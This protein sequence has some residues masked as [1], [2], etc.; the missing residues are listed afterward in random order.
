MEN[1]LPSCLKPEEEE[2][3]LQESL[4]LAE[5]WQNRATSILTHEERAIQ[6][7]LMRLLNH[8]TDKAVLTRLIDQSFRSS[9]N[10]RVADQVCWLLKKFGIPAYFP[11]S[12]RLLARLFLVVGRFFPEWAVPRMIE[13]MRSDSSRTIIH[14]EPEPFRAHM[15]KRKS[16]G[17]RMNINHLG[18]ALL[19][20]EEALRRL[21]K[22][23][24]ALESDE[25]EYISVKIS[26]IYSQIS[27]IGMDR[28]VAILKERLSQLYRTARD[29]CFTRPDGS[30][31][32]KFVNLDMEE[33]RDLDITTA[34]FT[35]TLDM[36]EFKNHSAGI[37][38]QAYLPDSHAIQRELTAWAQRRLEAG[39]SPVKLRIVKG[40]NM[41]MEQVE[42]SIHNWPLA[43]YDNKRDVDANYKRMVEF[44]MRPENIRA[45]NLGIASHNLF[46]VA[47]AFLLAKHYGVTRHFIFE[48]LEGMADHVRR[49]VQET[50]G[51]VLLYAPV[52]AKEQFINAI[53]YLVRRLDENT[54]PENFL[55]YAP[56]LKTGTKEW[57]FLREQFIEAFRH[58]NKPQ[59]T[60]HR[61][62]NR[63][64]ETFPVEMGTFT[65][66]EFLNEPDTDWALAPNRKW[67]E[68]I[69]ARWK[70]SPGD[71]PMEIPLAIAGNEIYEGRELRD[72]FDPSQFH[73]RVR[74]ARYAVAN[75][76]DVELAAATAKADPDGW[77][78]LAPR[79]R[80]AVLSKVAG[81]LRKARGDLIGAAAADTGKIFT[82][83]DGEVSEAI[84]FAEFYPHS[85]KAFTELA[86]V[87]A[88]GKG[89]VLVISPWNFPVS[90]PCGGIAASLAA[91]NR[92]IFKPASDAV[93]TAWVL[94][95]CFWK[96]GVSKNTLQFVPCPGAGTG[97][98]LTAHPAVNAII[99]TGGTD[100]GLRILKQRPNI[101]LNAETGGKNA[102]IVTA[103]SDRDQAVKNVVYSAFGNCGQKCSATSLLILD[104]EVHEDPAFREQLVDASAS[105]GVGSA[106]DF[107]NRM[108]PMIRPPSGDLENALTR[109]EP[110]E[111]WALKP[112]NIGGN[113]HTWSPGIKWNVQPR[114]YT[115]S[116]EFFG[117]VLAVMC[118]DNLDRAIELANM[119]GY[120]LTSGLE[121]LDVR[122]QERWKE[123]V[124]AGNLYVNRGTTGA[125]VLRQPFGGM[126]KSVIGSGMK[127]G[128]PD[129]VSQ[130][131]NFEETDFPAAGPIEKDHALLRLA[132]EWDLKIRWGEYAS[133]KADLEKTI[134]AIKSY[135]Y[136]FERH[137]AEGRDYFH[138]RGQD[139]IFRYLPVGA[140][141]VRL[142]EEDSLFEVL[143]RI[144]AAKISGCELRVSV[145]PNLSGPVVEFLRGKEGKHILGDSPMMVQS[146]RE[147]IGSM[148]SIRRIRYAAPGRVPS[149]V[150]L[151]AA[152]TGFYI[153]RTPVL[154]EG[155]IELLQY[156]L[157]QSICDSYH[158]Y[159]NL[160]ERATLK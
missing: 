86:G 150:Y 20:E 61:V 160:G 151:A 78:A 5:K 46:D 139:N 57:E 101:L 4:A 1:G 89:V 51:T 121:S 105:L 12:E 34:A 87:K 63:L 158:R 48:M 35:Q 152:E 18:E 128:G 129:Y 153:S 127:T 98:K 99:L 157:Q 107:E 31:T 16:E 43:P 60:P 140:V 122:E 65:K 14:G 2:R 82:E 155:R 159:G 66:G 41:E 38:L 27:S 74:I 117:P 52:A 96:A 154:M 125:I 59:T 102:T 73:D 156:L 144:A 109:L 64:T 130:F 3:I 44:G 83:A 95:Q 26:T 116:T 80:H 58:K 148:A 92:V 6:Q 62:Q 135:L 45:V 119:T 133:E 42:S 90:I 93:V 7:R 100:T 111:S 75:D 137:F 23:V 142:H 120:G 15:E 56:N 36:E 91:G 131:M 136:R 134:R 145:P 25:V 17:V 146:D 71:A 55:R 149:E 29:H 76:E 69:R 84:D 47:H 147:L 113:P 53:G 9:N 118:A 106:W 103:M 49:A 32:P 24:E 40:A 123:K 88:D 126:G 124:R 97:T 28:S 54:S 115:H 22:Y 50:A 114:S 67:A 30:R 39:G 37:V 143:A 132:Q 11:F 104:R 21:A 13:K 19:G 70:K 77:G 68:S 110:G 112:R 141:A 72:C 33:Y 138:L 94:C 108:G 81:E 79:E 10:G 85:V 8:P